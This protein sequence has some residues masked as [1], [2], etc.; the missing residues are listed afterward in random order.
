MRRKRQVEMTHYGEEVQHKYETKLQEQ[1][2]AMRTDFDSRIAAQ[3]ADVKFLF[4][5]KFSTSIFQVE[6]IF[7]GK[8][9]EAN[10]QATK[11]REA[12]ARAREEATS[13]GVR[14]RELERSTKDHQGI[15]DGLNRRVKVFLLN[16]K[17]FI[18]KL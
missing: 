6:D 17:K 15:V 4:L 5:N 1:L 8:L 2:H 10:N 13:L 18:L 12:S 16:V 9:Q 3:R 14:L 7:H 11:Y